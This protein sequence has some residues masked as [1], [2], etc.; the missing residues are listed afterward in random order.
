MVDG[1]EVEQLVPYWLVED[2]MFGDPPGGVA[3]EIVEEIV[4]TLARQAAAS[5]PDQED[6]RAWRRP[7]VPR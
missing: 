2:I 1:D 7:P 6:A 5:F 3:V 4:T